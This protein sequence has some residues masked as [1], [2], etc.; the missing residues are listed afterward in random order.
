MNKTALKRSVC[1]LICCMM[2]APLFSFGIR[3]EAVSSPSLENASA[4]YLH[5]IESDTTVLTKSENES[6]GAGASVKVLSGLLLCEMLADQMD[7]EIYIDAELMDQ[8]PAFTGRSLHI[9]S[10]DN[11]TVK[12]LLY[13]ALCGSYNDAFY[14]L[15]AYA[16]SSTE[17]FVERMNTR[18]KEIG[19]VNSIFEDPTGIVDGSRTS[20]ADMAR[21]A[22]VA[23]QNETYMQFCNTVSHPFSSMKLQKTIYNRNAL[24]CSYDTPKYYNKYC[25]GMSAGT[26]AKDGN[27][28]ITVAKHENE[29]YISVVLG[30]KEIEG[31]EFGYRIT[32][33]MIDWVYKNFSY[34][35]I[36]SPETEI[37]TIPVTVSDFTNELTV[38]TNETLYAYLPAGL[39]IGK[40]I[41]YS[42]RLTNTSLEAPVSENAFV[43]F[44]AI[45]YGERVL[46]T[47][48]LFTTEGA[49]RSGV[50]SS[51]QN[52]QALTSDRAVLSGIIFF[53]L[54]ISGWLLTEY[55]MIRRR[56]QKW[57]KYFSSKMELSETFIKPKDDNDQKNKKWK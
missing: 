47:V 14:L 54:A 41:T 53:V 43:G 52:I 13:A 20:A 24:I 3:A 18:A 40:D 7:A 48:R 55:L 2:L 8:L 21:I 38:R 28:V 29:T 35:E 57:D 45:M 17:S 16:T 44:V 30:G 37:C 46:G 49:E 31:V 25:T 56:R 39:E 34:V 42:I 12:E 22:M 9:E 1:F 15:G 50:V 36:I 26:T 51:L 33:Y 5:H 32:N 19:C 27:S 6:V 10:G 11:V 4:V 23:Y